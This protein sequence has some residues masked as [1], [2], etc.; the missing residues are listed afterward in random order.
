MDK[1]ARVQISVDGAEQGARA[2]DQVD[3]A[4]QRSTQ[5]I[6]GA[7]GRAAA[8]AKAFGAEVAK[9]VAGINLL[10]IDQA[11]GQVAAYEKQLTKTAIASGQSIE[12]LRAKYAD[13]GKTT[14]TSGS[15]IDKFT[16][17]LARQTGDIRGA[18]DAF[19]GLNAASLAA[20]DT[21]EEWI[22]FAE[23]LRNVYGLSGDT[24]G[25]VNKLFAEADKLGNVGGVR[26]LRDQFVALATTLENSVNPDKVEKTR[27]TLAALTKGMSPEQAKAAQQQLLSFLA[28]NYEGIERM[29]GKKVIDR[30]TGQLIDPA[31]TLKDLVKASDKSWGKGDLGAR[32]FMNALGPRLG[33]LVRSAFGNNA[34]ALE[35]D[36]AGMDAAEG[37]AARAAQ[38]AWKKSLAGR[39]DAA[40]LAVNQ[41]QKGQAGLLYRASGVVADFAAEHPGL[42]T[43]TGAVGGFLGRAV[44]VGGKVVD[45]AKGASGAIR[46]G[47][48]LVIDE[49]AALAG[50]HG[51]LAARLARERMTR[52]GGRL[53]GRA[54]RGSPLSYVTLEGDGQG[55]MP[56][57]PEDFPSPKA[58]SLYNPRTF[59]WQEYLKK[60][61]QEVDKAV[62]GGAI[63]QEQA[64]E[65]KALVDSQGLAQALGSTVLQV[66]IMSD[67]PVPA[68]SVEGD[69]GQSGGQ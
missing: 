5:G 32:A 12:Q 4:A 1:E 16:R 28:S 22:P 6:V 31:E 41:Y 54:M 2:F 47:S 38:E 13:I 19:A 29:T 48:A 44:G 68:Q 26:A 33:T 62:R 55:P 58:F 46:G 8:E 25:A 27:K 35:K 69:K 52:M 24:T 50:R 64:R 20:G 14:L 18:Q 23:A 17:R 66:R 7:F 34:A 3:R 53:L 51:P 36:V 61:P 10:S 40:E 59:G 37:D 67:V 42:A 11:I 30:K 56:D 39:K 57:H 49:A 15:E 60:H 43:V 63:S 45:L 65:I 21:A 9:A